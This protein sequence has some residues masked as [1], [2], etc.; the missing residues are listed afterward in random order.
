L[1][2]PPCSTRLAALSDWS[3]ISSRLDL[4]FDT[5]TLV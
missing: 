1:T 2:A 4:H 5:Y 3:V